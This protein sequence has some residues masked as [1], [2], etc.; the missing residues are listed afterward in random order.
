MT[1]PRS[2]KKDTSKNFL[3]FFI[4]LLFSFVLQLLGCSST[5]FGSVDGLEGGTTGLIRAPATQ[6]LSI[7]LPRIRRL[8]LQPNFTSKYWFRGATKHRNTGLPAMASPL[9]KGRLARKYLLM[10]V[11]EALRFKESPKPVHREE[12]NT[13]RLQKYSVRKPL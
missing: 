1:K 2:L 7:R 6:Q 11:R 10:M 3:A 12:K 5:F 9:A 4:K 13:V 8:P